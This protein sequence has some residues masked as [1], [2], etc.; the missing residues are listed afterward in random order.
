MSSALRLIVV[1]Q[2][3]KPSG[4]LGVPAGLIM[5]YRPSNR[6]RNLRTV[7]LLDIQPGDLVLEIGSGPGLA[8]QKVA[9]LATRGKVVGIDHSESM[10]KRAASRNAS[11][12]ASGLVEL[13][14]ASVYGMPSFRAPFDK[15]FAVNV[16]MF[17]RDKVEALGKLSKVLR[18]G[19]TLALTLQPRQARATDDDAELVGADI[20]RDM[21]AAGFSDIGT[22]VFEMKPVNAVCVCGTKP[23]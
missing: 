21:R 3:G 13:H 8:V 16:Y 4:L 14:V 2:F 11:A 18:P 9:S 23:G 22:T 20:A 10:V 5:E 7:N 6:I 1:R 15:A 19:G 12:I 17:W